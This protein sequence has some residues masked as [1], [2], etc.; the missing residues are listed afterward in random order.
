MDPRPRSDFFA[1]LAARFSL[2]VLPGF[3]VCPEG[4]DL[5]PMGKAYDGRGGF[6]STV[7]GATRSQGARAVKSRIASGWLAVVALAMAAC[8][9]SGAAAPKSSATADRPSGARSAASAKAAPSAGCRGDA[10]GLAAGEEKTTITS[11]GVER[12][13][14]RHVPP[15]HDITK[16]LPVVVDLHGY[17]EGAVVHARQS[18]LGAFG[19][20]HGFVTITP[21]GLGAVARWEAALG[22]ADVKFIGDLLDR[23]EQTVC[24]DTARVFFTGLSNGAMMT[25][26]VACALADRVAAVAPVAGITDVAGCKPALRV[27][28]VAFHGTADPFL[29]YDGG[30]GPSVA[31]LPA[32]DGSGKTLGELGARNRPKGPSVPDVLR[33]W[34]RRNGCTG[35]AS[36]KHIA[37]DVTELSFACPAGADVELFRVEGGGHSW[38]GS[39]FSKQIEAVVGPTTDSISADEVMWTFFQAHPLTR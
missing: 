14:L 16:P 11:G 24:V 20:R 5:D 22:S 26:V 1:F 2:R 10:A 4:G 32:P 12:W 25:S 28:I 37:A 21:Q 7:R 17:T 23:V 38:P 30:L 31:K 35:Q 18:D 36:E 15:A 19:D 9:G 3:F 39:A 29:A 34:A 13:Y 6:G 27:P 33:S 8:S